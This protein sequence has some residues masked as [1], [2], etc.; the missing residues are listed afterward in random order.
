MEIITDNA[1]LHNSFHMSRGD[2]ALW[3]RFLEGH[4][5]R[6]GGAAH[7]VFRRWDVGAHLYVILRL[8]LLN[9]AS[10]RH[11]ASVR[12]VQMLS[13]PFLFSHVRIP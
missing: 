8:G 10:V 9:Q 7:A 5:R 12:Q 6:T 1:L 3:P 4:R 2:I 11:Q 13:H